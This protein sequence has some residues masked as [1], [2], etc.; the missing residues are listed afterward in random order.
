L[1]DKLRFIGEAGEMRA[2]GGE[3]FCKKVRQKT[4][5][6]IVDKIAILQ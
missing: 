6:R 3:L 2:S 5:I 4:P 1:G